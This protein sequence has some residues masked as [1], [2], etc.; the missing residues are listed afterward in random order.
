MKVDIW[1]TINI[2]MIYVFIITII[3][4]I[5]IGLSRADGIDDPNFYQDF[6]YCVESW[7]QNQS[8][9]CRKYD[10][11]GEPKWSHDRKHFVYI[12]DDSEYIK[13]VRTVSVDELNPSLMIIAGT[14]M[15]VIAKKI[16]GDI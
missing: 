2:V 14:L 6:D 1:K 12:P 10:K 5:G 4:L 13:P 7:M 16:R 3:S 8:Q 11:L 9:F 15:V